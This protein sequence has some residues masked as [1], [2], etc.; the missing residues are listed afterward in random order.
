MKTLQLLLTLISL[1][2]FNCNA[3]SILLNDK[4]SC[5]AQLQNGER[6]IC[7]LHLNHAYQRDEFNLTSQQTRAIRDKY[8]DFYQQLESSKQKTS[9]ASEV[10][11]YLKGKQLIK[12]YL[13]VRNNENTMSTGFIIPIANK[14]KGGYILKLTK[15]S[16]DSIKLLNMLKQPKTT[17]IKQYNKEIKRIFTISA[18]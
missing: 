6:E 11:H 8:N 15:N 14:E 18:F 17:K 10:M 2:S 4:A 12:P 7:K 5:I 1:F 13:I 16:A 3:F 9:F